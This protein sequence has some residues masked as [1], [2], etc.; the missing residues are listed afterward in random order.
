MKNSKN[1]VHSSSTKNSKIN[2]RKIKVTQSM[3][4]GRLLKRKRPNKHLMED[5]ASFSCPNCGND[6]KQLL[7]RRRPGFYECLNPKCTDK[8]FVRDEALDIDE[9]E[10]E[11]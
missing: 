8:F 3:I 4:F 9:L 1:K 7:L 6:R 10:D 11:Y 5:R 2:K